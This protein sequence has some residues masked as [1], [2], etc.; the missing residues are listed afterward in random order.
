MSF[1]S[2]KS[3]CHF[4]IQTE[5]FGFPKLI[6]LEDYQDK[7]LQRFKIFPEAH[8]FF[9]QI[10]KKPCPRNAFFS[11][12]IVQKK[13]DKTKTRALCLLL[14]I[15]LAP[16]PP[17]YLSTQH[18]PPIYILWFTSLWG[19]AGY[20]SPEHSQHSVGI[21]T[22]NTRAENRVFPPGTGIQHRESR[23]WTHILESKSLSHGT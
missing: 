17:Y 5:R 23:G 12:F 15:T 7:L 8:Y 2:E 14:T 13:K 16:L 21:P 19:C 22:T 20:V 6:A 10:C 3:R 9:F 4:S 18:R 11:Q 1:Q